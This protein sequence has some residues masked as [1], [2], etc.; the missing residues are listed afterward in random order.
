[1]AMAIEVT[2]RMVE[3]GLKFRLVVL[4]KLVLCKTS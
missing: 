4:K 2:E 1:M 3:V